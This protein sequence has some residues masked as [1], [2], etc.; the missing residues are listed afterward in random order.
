M[1]PLVTDEGRALTEALPAAQAGEGLL[2]RVGPLV[3]VE[4]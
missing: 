2:P 3:P 4:M 1:D